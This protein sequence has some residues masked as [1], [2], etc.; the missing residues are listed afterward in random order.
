M[1]EKAEKDQY[2]LHSSAWKLSLIL[3]SVET[4]D[5]SL[6]D[7]VFCFQLILFDQQ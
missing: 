4:K 6:P 3:T 5:V 7:P 2:I 1:K